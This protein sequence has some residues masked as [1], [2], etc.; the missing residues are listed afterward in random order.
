[1]IICW[2]NLENIRLSIHGNF[3]DIVKEITYKYKESCKQCNEPFLGMSQ[4]EFCSIE[5]RIS[6]KIIRKKVSNSLKGIVRSNYT[7]KKMSLSKSN[8]YNVNIPLYDTYSPQLEWCEEVR[9]NK[10]DPNVLEVKC[11]KCDKWYISTRQSIRHR[12]NSI[13]GYS[14]GQQHFYCSD[15]CKHSCSIF[16]K[17]PEQ[18]M[19]DDLVRSGR[20]KWLEL[21]REIQPEL[22]QMVLKRD[23]YMCIKCGNTNELQCHHI[24]PVNIEPL[25]SADIDN[26]ITLCKGCHIKIHKKDGCRY[27]QLKINICN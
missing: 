19:K 15:E 8:G 11:F 13:N 12:I 16:G 5:C 2:D 14:K 20:L 1:M 23:K 27:N 25:L 4:N 24:M 17:K 18:I 26:C 22:R 7:K 6:S 3:R 10:E 9:R 21:K